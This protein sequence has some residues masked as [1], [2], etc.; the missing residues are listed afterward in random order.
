MLCIF[1]FSLG[2]ILIPKVGGQ[3]CPQTHDLSWVEKA[4]SQ[5]FSKADLE[6][7]KIVTHALSAASETKHCLAAKTL[8]Q[9]GEEKLR[10][11]LVSKGQELHHANPKGMDDTCVD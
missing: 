3:S 4:N 5:S 11:T 1:V 6:A 2:I 7:Q 10:Q 8:I 9:Q